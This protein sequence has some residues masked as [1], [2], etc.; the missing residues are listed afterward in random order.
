VYVP[1][2]E[3][4]S[5]NKYNY[6]NNNTAFQGMSRGNAVKAESITKVKIKKS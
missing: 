5:Y 2:Q 6:N 3:E 4:T 1:G